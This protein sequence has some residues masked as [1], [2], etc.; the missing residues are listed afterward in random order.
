MG[1]RTKLRF[2]GFR[3][4]E[5][6]LRGANSRHPT[7]LRIIRL[8]LRSTFQQGLQTCIHG[9]QVKRGQSS[10]QALESTHPLGAGDVSLVAT[11]GGAQTPSGVVISVQQTWMMKHGD[12]EGSVVKRTRS[13]KQV[14]IESAFLLADFPLQLRNPLL[15]PP[16]LA[17]EIGRAHV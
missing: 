13:L 3:K 10:A 8:L 2:E 11:V 7:L 9:R 4:R 1:A 14:F 16:L 5:I 6:W 15:R 12:G 17:I